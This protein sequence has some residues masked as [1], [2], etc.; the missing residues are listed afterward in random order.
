MSSSGAMNL[1][2]D[3]EHELWFGDPDP[4]RTFE[5]AAASLAAAVADATGLKPFPVVAAE[6]LQLM[7]NPNYK[8]SRLEALI[9][10]DPA[11]SSAFLRV[12][13]SALYR[14]A[15]PCTS[16]ADSLVRLGGSAVQGIV[17]GI[18]TLGMFEDVTGAGQRVRNHCAGVAAVARMLGNVWRLKAVDEL[19]LA[20]LMHDIGKLLLIQIGAYDYSDVPSEMLERPDLA[21]VREREQLG[22][23][24]AVLGAHVLQK[25]GLPD[26]VPLLASWHHQ[27]ARAYEAGGKVGLMTALLRMADTLDHQIE[28]DRAP[29]PDFIEALGKSG[30]CSYAG[31]DAGDVALCWEDIV[32]ARD[33][34]LN[35]FGG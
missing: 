4:K 15:V 24:H 2:I 28:L 23:D 10:Q 32:A 35:I 12:A 25:W 34:V 30:A 16:V 22:Y 20:G 26:P 1:E 18:S 5:Q 7:A 33:E 13:N 29:N 8:V 21:Q 19:F 17:A 9:E 27:P 11:L 6:V 3:A 14:R 31:L